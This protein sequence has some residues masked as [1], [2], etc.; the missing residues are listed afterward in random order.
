MTVEGWDT[1]YDIKKNESINI[2][3]AAGFL[4]GAG[5]VMCYFL[6]V[7]FQQNVAIR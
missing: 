3:V 1:P 4:F 5:V 7:L 6:A 2:K